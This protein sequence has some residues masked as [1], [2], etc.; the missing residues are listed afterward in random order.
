M[1]PR[2]SALIVPLLVCLPLFAAC[3]GGPAPEF[4]DTDTLSVT[5]YGDR[6]QGIPETVDI[7]CLDRP[8]VCRMISRASAPPDDFACAE[9]YGGPERIVVR[10]TINGQVIDLN[11][12]RNNSCEISLYDRIAAAT[13]AGAIS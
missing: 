5:A 6:A 10:G 8:G 4:A 13:G 3:G 7:T 12:G 2:G 1:R 9:I 11:A